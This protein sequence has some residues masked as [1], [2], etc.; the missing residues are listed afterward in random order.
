VSSTI[1]SYQLVEDARAFLFPFAELNLEEKI[2]IKVGATEFLVL[3]YDMVDRVVPGTFTSRVLA[4][5]IL[6]RR[7]ITV[8]R[9]S[10]TVT[11]TRSCSR[12]SETLV[13]R[14]GYTP[15]SLF[16]L[17]PPCA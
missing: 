6:R 4:T 11:I 3:E 1:N 5:F 8:K 13:A 9:D 17:P 2:G 12:R 10:H 14:V 15:I 16:P 7:E